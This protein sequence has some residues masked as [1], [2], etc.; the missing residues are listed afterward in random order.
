[1]TQNSEVAELLGFEEKRG[2][3][4]PPN[5]ETVAARE[6]AG[7]VLDELTALRRA[8]DGNDP[9]PPNVNNLNVADV[10]HGVTVGW[11]A[12]AFS[13]DPTTVKKKLRDCVPIYRRKTGYVYDL[14]MAARHLVKPVFD[15][16]TYLKSMKPSELPTHLQDSYWSAMR[17]RQQWEVDAGHLWRTESVL[18]VFGDVFQTIKFAIQLWPDLIERAVGLTAEQR[19]MLIGMC[20]ELQ[21]EIHTK[22][23]DLPTKKRTE[24]MLA[25]KHGGEDDPDDYSHL[26]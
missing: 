25:E 1:M 5:P 24:P 10:M 19:K 3:G 15:A 9:R 26:V 23:V 22:L 4:R 6:N 13:M 14:K 16:E 7:K 18:E 17:K 20:D 8:A 12:Q 21:K 11:L 2:P